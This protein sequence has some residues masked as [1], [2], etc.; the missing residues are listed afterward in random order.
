MESSFFSDGNSQF[1]DYQLQYFAEQIVAAC[2]R[3]AGYV[4]GAFAL[5]FVSYFLFIKK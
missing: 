3:M 2:H 4:A 5:L 1:S